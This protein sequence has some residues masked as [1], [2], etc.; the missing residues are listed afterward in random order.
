MTLPSLSGNM[1]LLARG[2]FLESM[3]AKLAGAT[4]VASVHA[5]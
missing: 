2:F 4:I 1:S 3:I 5:I